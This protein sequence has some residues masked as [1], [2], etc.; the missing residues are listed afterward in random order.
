MPSQSK[1][2]HLIVMRYFFDLK[3]SSPLGKYSGTSPLLV[4]IE[5]KALGE[6][7]WQDSPVVII[8]D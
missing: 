5:I 3:E 6:L 4:Y 8:N 2:E 1:E 7:G